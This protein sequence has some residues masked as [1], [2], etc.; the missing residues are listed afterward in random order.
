M[1]EKKIAVAVT[2]VGE[3]LFEGGV[4]VDALL[5]ELQ[6]LLGLSQDFGQ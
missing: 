4:V 5:N 1:V 6:P 2:E 3:G